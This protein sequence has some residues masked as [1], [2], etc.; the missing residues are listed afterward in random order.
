MSSSPSEQV[1]PR[2][3]GVALPTGATAELVVDAA[4]LVALGAQDVEPAGLLDL[5]GLAG[6]LVLDPGERLVPRRLVVLAHVDRV[7]ALLAQAQVGEE[8]G[9]A[10]EHDVGPAARHVRRDRDRP[11]PAGLGDDPGLLLV[12]LGVQHEV[13]HPALGEQLGEVLGALDARRPDEDR[14]A[15]LEVLGDVVGDGLELRRLGLVDQVG[16][17]HALRRLVG[18]DGD[19]AELVGLGE[20]GR[21]GLGGTGHPRE[22]LVEPE[23]VLQRDRREG[24]VL[25]LDLDAFLGLDR[26]VQ[27]LV[28]AAAGEDAAGELVDDQD[29]AVADDVVL[30]LEEELLDLDRVVQVADERSVRGL[31]EVL[32]AQLVLD[33]PDA[34]LGDA[35]GLLALVDLVVDVL[36]H[37]RR[38][39]GELGVPAGALLGRAR[40][41]QRRAGL[42]DE[43]RV[44]LVDDRVDVP[45]LHA[46]GLRPGHVVAQVVEAELVVRAVGD[47]GGVGRAALVGGHLRVDRADLEA[48]EA[49]DAAHPLRVAAGEVVVGGDDVDALAGDRVEVGRQRRD[50]RLALTGAHLGD[51]AQ[52][53]R[54]AAHE[55]D[56]VVALAEGAGGALADD[57]ERLAEQ[58]VEGLAVGVAVPELLG[59]RAQLVV[60]ESLDLVAEGVDVVRD[61]AETPDRPRLARPQQSVQH[62]DG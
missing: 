49:V 44:D 5:L 17:I 38:E 59:L 53:Q 24:L 52:V 39:P 41:D 22:L 3:A 18:R 6:D 15:P 13:L 43:D 25:L 23:V 21:L 27:A 60:R 42:V 16:L 58:V 56:P 36:G 57:R 28:V 37:L 48:E 14:L 55:L 40:D 1:E 11:T 62:H 31:V 35:D 45:A 19:D 7:E 47:V 34:V 50:Q 61:R 20:L 46:L 26:L 8:V 33:E 10:A 51:V 32:D 9:V 29:L 30:V 12:E 54:G 2:L 4:R